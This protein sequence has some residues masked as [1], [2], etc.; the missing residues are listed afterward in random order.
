MALSVMKSV[1]AP[2]MKNVG[3]TTAPISYVHPNEGSARTGAINKARQ[4]LAKMYG[5]TDVEKVPYRIVHDKMYSH[6]KGFEAEVRL[7]RSND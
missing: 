4:E 1:E 6:P 7:V 3:D 5:E 2:Q